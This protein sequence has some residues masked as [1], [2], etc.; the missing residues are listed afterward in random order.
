MVKTEEKKDEKG[1]KK[2]KLYN[3]NLYTSDFYSFNFLVHLFLYFLIFCT[4]YKV[5]KVVENSFKF[6]LI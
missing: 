6:I 1:G 4:G 5:Y 2:K 3:Y